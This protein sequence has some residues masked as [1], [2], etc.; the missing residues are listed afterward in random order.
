MSLEEGHWPS[1]KT[2]INHHFSSSWVMMYLCGESFIG[3]FFFSTS[4]NPTSSAFTFRVEPLL[5]ASAVSPQVITR[6]SW[7][8][9]LLQ[10]HFPSS[11]S[12]SPVF[13]STVA[14]WAIQL[15]YTPSLIPFWR[16][17]KLWFGLLYPFP[18]LLYSPPCLSFH[19]YCP[20]L[21]QMF[22][23]CSCFLGLTDPKAW[24]YPLP[25]FRFLRV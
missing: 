11:S 21:P 12:S 17:L 1:S 3:P 22:W 10:S 23:A 4:T 7:L 13:P 16:L 9:F 6:A 24:H 8:A 20:D 15:K 25:L 19:L 2:N 5:T 18:F 14:A